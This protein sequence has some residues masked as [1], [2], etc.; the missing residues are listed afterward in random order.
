M[1]QSQPV[2]KDQLPSS[3][4]CST[5]TDTDIIT[6]CSNPP[7]AALDAIP[8]GSYSNSVIPLSDLEVVKFGPGVYIE[9]YMNLQR[10][11]KLLDPSIVRVP[12]PYRFIRNGEVGYIVMEYMR[13][14][15]LG[16]LTDPC[17]IEKVGKA[18]EHFSSFQ[19]PDPGPLGGGISR[20]LLWSEGTTTE[21]SLCASTKRL[22]HWFNRRIKH[23]NLTISFQEC[24]F[25]LCHLDIAPRN[26]VWLHNDDSLCIVDWASAGY[27]PRIFEWCLLDI[28]LG[29]D[30]GF[31][32]MVKKTMEPLSVWENENWGLV[33]K[34]WGNSVGYHLYVVF[35]ID[36]VVLLVSNIQVVRLHPKTMDDDSLVW[37]N[38]RRRVSW[39]YVSPQLDIRFCR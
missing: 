19:S 10:A 3:L 13:G 15:V 26:I 35:P 31:Q 11:Y 32:G 34:A 36:L 30:G 37:E 5:L 39:Q 16:N 12:Q 4:H 9:E 17:R 28:F 21:Y 6:Y 2:E 1:A 14:T 22:E 38:I 24:E 7:S 29:R 33:E 18:L 25:V 23:E 20:D 27:Y 8:L